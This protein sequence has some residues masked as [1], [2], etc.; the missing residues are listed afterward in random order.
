MARSA[1]DHPL[2][3]LPRHHPRRPN[4]QKQDDDDISDR[5][6][7]LSWYYDDCLQ[8]WYGEGNEAAVQ[9]TFT[10]TKIGVWFVACYL[11][12]RAN[13]FWKI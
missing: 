9:L 7:L 8:K 5:A 13:V 6:T 11:L 4:Q 12:Y 10:L 2:G 3:T 1:D